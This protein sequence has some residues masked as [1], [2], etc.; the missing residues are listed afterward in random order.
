MGSRLGE[1]LNAY[2]D[3]HVLLWLLAGDLQHIST[4]AQQAIDDATLLVSPMVLLESEYLFEINR[5]YIS[6]TQVERRMRQ[7]L[8]IEVCDLPFQ[9]VTDVALEESWTRD[10]FDRLIVAQAKARGFWP[11]ISADER[12]HKHYSEAYW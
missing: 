1:T 7:A 12:I 6:A 10:P 5:T 2:L 8:N 11:L 4:K 3:T 9:Q